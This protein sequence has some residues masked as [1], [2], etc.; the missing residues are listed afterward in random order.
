M[1]P[2]KELD[3]HFGVRI[4]SHVRTLILDLF[5]PLWYNLR[6]RVLGAEG[7]LVTIDHILGF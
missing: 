6:P 4:T 2:N 7:D 1:L 3:L 5:R